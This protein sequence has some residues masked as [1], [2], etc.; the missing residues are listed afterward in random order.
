MPTAAFFRKHGNQA[1]GKCGKT[2][3]NMRNDK[4]SFHRQESWDSDLF[5]S[6]S[7]FRLSAA[8]ILPFPDEASMRRGEMKTKEGQMNFLNTYGLVFAK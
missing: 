2:G 6:K 7:E 3:N 8:D 1:D 5:E 4:K